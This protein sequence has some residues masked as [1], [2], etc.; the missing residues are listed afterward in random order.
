MPF[1]G[2]AEKGV[3]SCFLHTPTELMDD[4]VAT[5]PAEA[6][7]HAGHRLFY[8]ELLEMHGLH[9][10][11]EYIAIGSRLRS[12]ETLD[13]VGGD[14]FLSEVLDFVPT[15][16]HYGLYKGIL[17]DKLALRRLITACDNGKAS[18]YKHQEDVT[19]AIDECQ[20]EVLAVS[21]VRE[22]R[23]PVP[24]K[25]VAMEAAEQI[26]AQH[27]NPGKVAG[28]VCGLSDL[29]RV[30]NGF[31]KKDR[32][33]FCARPSVGKTSLLM[34]VV[35]HLA[36]ENKE[37][38]VI[39]SLDGDR[40]GLMRRGIALRSGIGL[41]KIRAGFLQDKEDWAKITRATSDWMSAPF[42]IDDRP[43]VTIQEMGTILRRFKKKHGI[44]WA[45][46]DFY[47]KMKSGSKRSERGDLRVELVECSQGWMNLMME[48]DLAGI[49]LAQLSRESAK[50]KKRPTMEDILESG[51]AEQDAT[52]I[53]LMSTDWREWEEI[54]KNAD[55][56][57]DKQDIAAAPAPRHDDRFVIADVVKN[58][59]GPTGP[60]WLRLRTTITKFESFVP[61]KKL[62]NSQHNKTE[63]LKANEAK[64]QE[65]QAD[66][67]A[68]V[69]ESQAHLKC[70]K[71]EMLLPEGHEPGED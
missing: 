28:M 15:P 56:E 21:L 64:E 22:E 68:P 39:F 66:R 26:E 7:Y 67:P 19:A 2:D 51:A 10:P 55:E 9:L 18:C 52:K 59:D 32:I 35:N 53:V 40:T 71:P 31:E 34:T 54:K 44:T 12:K 65:R 3:L 46:V 29:D 33:M 30:L 62:Y 60:Q 17:L 69:P 48:L 70:P 61:G 49:M 25:I 20:R 63:R 57:I 11:I 43:G 16:T 6:F 24:A 27:R 42:F 47:Q 5:L 45:A 8:E 37:P 36:V 38:G 14:G 58:K 41:G 1:D 4:A 13:K 23:G 50:G